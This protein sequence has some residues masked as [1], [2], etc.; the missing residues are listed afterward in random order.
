VS[1][2]GRVI[3]AASPF[4]LLAAASGRT[5][6]HFPPPEWAYPQTTRPFA[7]DPDDGKPKRL[8]GST[9]ACTYQ[10]IEDSFAP[11]GLHDIAAYAGSQAP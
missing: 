11:A 1:G 7:S 9:R 2:A 6:D 3:L 4:T 8:P 10:Q 5:A